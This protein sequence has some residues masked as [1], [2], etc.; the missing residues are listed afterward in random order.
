LS[1]CPEGAR[2]RITV[3]VDEGVI[4]AFCHC[5]LIDAEGI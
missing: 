4:T 3:T 2:C 1:A 5:V